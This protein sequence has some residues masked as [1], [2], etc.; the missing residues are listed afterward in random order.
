MRTLKCTWS[1]KAGTQSGA[2]HPGSMLIIT[3]ILPGF[4]LKPHLEIQRRE[5]TDVSQYCH[6]D[7]YPVKPSSVSKSN[8]LSLDQF[9]WK[10]QLW[11]DG[12]R[13]KQKAVVSGKRASCD[14]L[15]ERLKLWSN[16]G[17]QIP[18]QL[19]RPNLVEQERWPHGKIVLIC[20]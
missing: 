12:T 13:K 9:K 19:Q 14:G 2:F 6:W 11:D 1:G 8:P 7:L 10:M 17:W 5:A 18:L 3:T 4:K 20:C 16:G 15:W